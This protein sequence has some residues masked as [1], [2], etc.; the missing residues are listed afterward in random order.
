MRRHVVA[1]GLTDDAK[2]AALDDELNEEIARAIKE[3]ED[4]PPPDR[5]SLFE[6]VYESLPWHLR[7][8]E[9]LEGQ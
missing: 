2:D 6:D 8:Q 7:E 1:Q 9:E 5:A 3:V 4:Y